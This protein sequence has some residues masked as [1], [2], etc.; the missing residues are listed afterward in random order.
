LSAANISAISAAIMT[1][2][3]KP[4]NP[5][6]THWYHRRPSYWFRKDRDRMPGTNPV[7]ILMRLDPKPG[8]KRSK[9]PPVRIFLGTEPAQHRAERVFVFS[10]EKVRDPARA[11]EVHLMK[12]I[13]GIDR[14]GWKTGFTNYRY[15]IPEW[16]GGHGRAIY[17]DVDQ[18]YLADPAEMFDMDMKGAGVAAISEAENSVMLIDCAKMRPIWNVAAVREGKGH[19]HFKAAMSEAKL[20]TPLDEAWN[21]R[22]GAVPVEKTKCLHYTTLHTQPWEPFPDQLN[23]APSPLAHVWHDLEK[24]ADAAGYTAFT[25]ER[26][27]PLYLELLRQYEIM[28]KRP[29]PVAADGTREVFDGRR[30]PKSAERISRLI[31]ETGA[32]TILDYGSGKGSFYQPWPGEAGTSRFKSHP[33]WPGVKVICFDPGYAPFSQPW[34]ETV[35]GVVSTDVVEHIPSD[36][37]PWIIDEMFG[38]AQKF[39]YVVAACY[40]AE[41]NLPNGRNAHCT[42]EP[43]EWW[44]MQMELASRRSPGRIWVLGCDERGAFGKSRSYFSGQDSLAGDRLS[45]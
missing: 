19:A 7:P 11:Y 26:P 37:V 42:I 27:S 1:A 14:K 32:R 9:K 45:A 13:A 6:K 40:P 31:A 39:V 2:S 12:D 8:V 16:A 22:D 23:Y 36:D 10:L 24:E 43:A 41:K 20:W 33:A 30:L 3:A 21:S 17:N 44:R 18:I 25:E 5:Y 29:D 38:K 15:A 28:H 34:T 4:K 35:D